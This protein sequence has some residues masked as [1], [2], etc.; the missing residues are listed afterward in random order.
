MTV[1]LPTKVDKDEAEFPCVP[2][3]D[4]RTE[5]QSNSLHLPLAT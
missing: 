4:A 5:E 2:K 1:V 3:Q